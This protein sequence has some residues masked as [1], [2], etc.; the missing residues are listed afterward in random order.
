MRAWNRTEKRR[1]PF[2]VYGEAVALTHSQR[3]LNRNSGLERGAFALRFCRL[4]KRE[5]RQDKDEKRDKRSTHEKPPTPRKVRVM[6]T[7]SLRALW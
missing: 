6:Q 5:E 7:S 1:A 4:N 2:Q 3:V